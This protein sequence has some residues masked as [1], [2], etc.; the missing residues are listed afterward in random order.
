ME[1]TTD[2]VEASMA[3]RSPAG[4]GRVELEAKAIDRDFDGLGLLKSGL[5]ESGTSPR[6]SVNVTGKAASTIHAWRAQLRSHSPLFARSRW[7]SLPGNAPRQ[8][9]IRVLPEPGLASTLAIGLG[10]LVVLGRRRR[11]DSDSSRR[12][13]SSGIVDRSGRYPD[14]SGD[15]PIL[16][17]G[18]RRSAVFG[19]KGGRS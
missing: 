18:A 11:L 7:I 1:A 19:L 14:P 15:R 13:R 10:A 6:Q 16:V 4:R 8:F 3:L 5:L 9:D 12:C 17:N 2:V